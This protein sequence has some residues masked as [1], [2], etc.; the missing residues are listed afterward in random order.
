MALTQLQQ[1][2]KIISRSMCTL[3]IVPEQASLDAIASMIALF[4]TLEAQR[5]GSVDA[6][7]HAHVPST[8]QFLPGSS[9]VRT[10]PKRSP[11]IVLDIADAGQVTDIR[12]EKIQGGLRLHATFAEGTTLTRDQIELS[13]HSAPYDAIIVFGAADLEA[14]GPVYTEHTDF[15]YHTPTINVDRRADN[16]QFGTVNLVDITAGSI[17]EVTGDLISHLTGGVLDDAQA[18]ALY[19]GIV[20]GTDSFQKPSTTPRSFQMAAKLMT[21]AIDRDQIIQYL[22]KTKP[23]EL[24]KLTGRAYARLRYDEHLRLFWSL[25]RPIDFQESGGSA[26]DIPKVTRELVNN[27]AGYTAAFILY[28]DTDQRFRIFLQLGQGLNQ[29]RAEIQALLSASQDQGGLVVALSAHSL[30]EAERAALEKIRAFLPT[31]HSPY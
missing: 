11:E 20:A 25:V 8:L 30:E 27:I 16:E 4:L 23:I 9:Q 7:S 22:I 14:L 29:Q 24:L 13:V 18:T 6:V 10:W 15:F 12:Q 21:Y 17:A 31:A 2:E 1:A 3:L 5:S 28:E 26:A 19:A